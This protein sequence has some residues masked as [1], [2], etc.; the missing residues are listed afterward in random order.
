MKE[1]EE[2]AGKEVNKIEAE[3]LPNTEFKVMVIRMFKE[4]SEDYNSMKK[5]LETKKK[6]T[7]EN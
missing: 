3:N 6:K 2:S 7:V 1:Q 5:D 4:L